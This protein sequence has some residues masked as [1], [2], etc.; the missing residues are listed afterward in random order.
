MTNTIFFT[1]MTILTINF[2]FGTMSYFSIHRTFLGLYRATFE[3]S[4]NF[5]NRDGNECDPYFNKKALEKN[6]DDY[7]SYS[8]PR[9]VKEYKIGIYYFDE[10]TYS[11]CTNEYCYNVKI[12]LSARISSLFNYENARVYSIRKGALYVE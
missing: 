5:F 8:L 2:S 12:S 3:T 9:Y 6:V 7:F 4:I 10:D 11:Y 1:L